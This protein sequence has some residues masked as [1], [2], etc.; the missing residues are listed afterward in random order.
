MSIFA[1]AS[2]RAALLFLC[3]LFLASLMFLGTKDISAGG[4]IEEIDIISDKPFCQNADIKAFLDSVWLNTP[5]MSSVESFT[6]N[7]WIVKSNGDPIP[8]T[9]G[10]VDPKLKYM[11]EIEM[12]LK[13]GK[14]FNSNDHLYVA[15]NN[16][17]ID[18]LGVIEAGTDYMTG[19]WWLEPI[20]VYKVTF[21]TDGGKP[22][23]PTQFVVEGEKVEFP[24]EPIKKGYEF[25]GWWHDVPRFSEQWFFNQALY[26]DLPLIAHWKALPTTKTTTTTTKTTT[27]ATTTTASLETE[28]TTLAE[29]FSTTV[30]ES[31]DTATTTEMIVPATSPNEF[32]ETTSPSGE[33]GEKKG[34]DFKILLYVL[35]GAALFVIFGTVVFI[36][37]RK[38]K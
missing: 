34:F 17:E 22:V 30:P 13:S 23:P 29:V 37:G 1:K 12:K 8:A 15:L 16:E 21:N 10:K 24:E 9:S 14:Y 18:F 35:G 28:P 6:F 5:D 2:K 4:Y 7:L 25:L 20:P 36:L 38:S 3:L 32:N 33:A 19:W 31:S 11:F 26:Q 27:A